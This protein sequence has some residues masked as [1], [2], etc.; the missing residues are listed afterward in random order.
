M[1]K[2]KKKTSSAVL[3]PSSPVDLIPLP[4]T[5]IPP[6]T[7]APAPTP[8]YGRTDTSPSEMV[9]T[10]N[11]ILSPEQALRGYPNG[12]NNS[13]NIE[14][15]PVAQTSEE[16]LAQLSVTCLRFNIEVL[17]RARAS[18]CVHSV[19]GPWRRVAA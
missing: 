15:P 6:A 9:Y 19:S 2:K 1:L 11:P 3:S 17:S 12:Y 8:I 4:N 13:F 5:S 18:G 14:V 7:P 16:I 10:N